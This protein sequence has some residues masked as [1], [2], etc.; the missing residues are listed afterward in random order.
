MCMACATGDMC[1]M[2]SDCESAFCDTDTCA[3]VVCGDGMAQGPED[4]DDGSGGVPAE[5]ATCDIDCTTA[6]CGDGTVNV[7]AS[8]EC[9]GDGAGTGRRDRHLRRRLHR[10]HLRRRQRQHDGRR[11][12]RRR[13]RGHRRRDGHL[14][15]R[16]HDLDVRRRRPQRHRRRGV[17]RR[18]H[19]GRRPLLQHVHGAGPRAHDRGHPDLRHRHR[20]ARRHGRHGLGRGVLDPHHRR[21]STSPRAQPCRSSARCPSRCRP[22]PTSPSRARST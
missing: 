20:R 11:G 6:M 18:Q 14:Q 21:P 16:L 2:D 5:S 13:R 8:E 3:D 19:G 22:R 7:T 12:L 17:R 4:C 1:T 15:H 10:G 9:D